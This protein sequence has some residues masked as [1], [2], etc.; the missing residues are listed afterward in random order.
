MNDNLTYHFIIEQGTLEWFDLKIG[1]ISGT[2]CQTLLTD[3]KGKKDTK[4]LGTGA[5]Q[6]VLKKAAEI[7]TGSPSVQFSGNGVTD[8][9][10]EMEP[11]SIQEY[12]LNELCVVETVGFVQDGN[13]KGFS[14][15]GIVGDTGLVESKCLQP[16]EHLKKFLSKKIDKAHMA[17]MQWGLFVSGRVWYDNIYYNPKFPEGTDYFKI[18]VERD[19]EMIEKFKIRSDQAI[20]EICAILSNT[21]FNGA[22]KTLTL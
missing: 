2:S 20:K 10:N 4:E 8:W 9:G 22:F 5:K 12:E 11:L 16:T 17:Q 1:K 18:R 14:P 21:K 19:E 7:I 3:P 15:D 6:M 13:F